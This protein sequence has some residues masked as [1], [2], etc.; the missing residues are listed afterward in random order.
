M[1]AQNTTK[2]SKYWIQTKYRHEAFTPLA[3]KKKIQTN[4]TDALHAN[5]FQ[6]THYQLFI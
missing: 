5:K 3:Q 2:Y 6:L 1:N 4:K